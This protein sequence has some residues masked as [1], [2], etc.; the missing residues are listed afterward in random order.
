MI[1]EETTPDMDNHFRYS[2][3]TYNGFGRRSITAE[4]E[5]EPL[6]VRVS[7][8]MDYPCWSELE[9]SPVW[10]SVADHVRGHQTE[11]THMQLLTPAEIWEAAA[12]NSRSGWWNRRRKWVSDGFRCVLS[13]IRNQFGRL[14][15][16]L[17]Q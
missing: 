15:K 8:Y 9:K 14:Y 4:D 6:E 3:V 13:S 11:R 1:I 2:V 7:F 16:E 17:F 12:Y 5:A 10:Q